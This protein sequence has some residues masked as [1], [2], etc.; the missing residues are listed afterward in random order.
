MG[1]ILN[2]DISGKFVDVIGIKGGTRNISDTAIFGLRGLYFPRG[3]R[4]P[5]EPPPSVLRVLAGGAF[6]AVNTDDKSNAGRHVI[7]DGSSS[8]GLENAD[9]IVDCEWRCFCDRKIS[10]KYM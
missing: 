7:V 4:C 10:L 2:P 6:V 5:R 3:P 1:C 9:K 8:S